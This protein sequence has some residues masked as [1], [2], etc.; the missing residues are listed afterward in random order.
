MKSAESKRLA[1]SGLKSEPDFSQVRRLKDC[2]KDQISKLLRWLD[3]SGLALY[4]LRQ[5]HQCGELESVPAVLQEALGARY[6]SN[7]S[8]MQ[9]LFAEFCAVNAVLRERN[10]PH[11]FLKG[12]TLVPDFCP[13]PTFRH[14]SDLDLLVSP[15]YVG[16]TSQA[17]VDMGYPHLDERGPNEVRHVTSLQRVPTLHDDIYQP[18][19]QREIEL[20][21][22]IWNG[23][24]GVV[25]RVPEGCL[26]RTRIRVLNGHHYV[27]LSIEDMF[28]L[29][30]LHAF[31]HFLGSWV[32]VAWLWEIHYFIQRHAENDALWEAIRGRVGEDLKLRKAIGLVVALTQRLFG[33]CV[34]R[35]LRKLSVDYLPDHLQA[36]VVKYGTIWALADI[37][38]S[39]LS[40]FIHGEFFDQDERDWSAYVL[41]RIL[42]LPARSSPRQVESSK[43]T[44]QLKERMIQLKFG[45]RRVIFHAGSAIELAWEGLRWGRVLHSCRKKGALSL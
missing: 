27:S 45:A 5:L 6:H 10:I 39:K 28:L 9:R 29:Q 32:R 36:W 38:G 44:T 12:F 2:R 20:H 40:L 43:R 31:S 8:R 18:P 4:F 11:A 41:R 37:S 35:P 33:T 26:A 25:L 3:H 14:Q 42:P 7:C 17:L 22:S 19:P 30:T 1:I 16:T 13:D 24:G 21:T 34:P 23:I 15:E